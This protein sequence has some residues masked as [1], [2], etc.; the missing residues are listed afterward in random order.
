MYVRGRVLAQLRDA[1][2]MVT[3]WSTLFSHTRSSLSSEESQR[4]RKTN[5]TRKEDERPKHEAARKIGGSGDQGEMEKIRND[6]R[7]EIS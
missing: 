2:A 7:E 1:V 3:V 6:K 5:R 4:N